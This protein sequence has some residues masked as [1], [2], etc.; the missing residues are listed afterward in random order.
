MKKKI[1]LVTSLLILTILL[2]TPYFTPT[3]TAPTPGP[4]PV[5]HWKIMLA[6]QA[7]N[8]WIVGWLTF[9]G[10]PIPGTN[11]FLNCTCGREEPQPLGQ[12]VFWKQNTSVIPTDIEYTKFIDYTKDGQP[13]LVEPISALIPS[14]GH[15]T[16]D[17]PQTWY[18]HVETGQGPYGPWMVVVE[19]R[20]QPYDSERPYFEWQLTMK[21]HG[22][23]AIL[24]AYLTKDQA[25]LP[26][27]DYIL[28]GTH[29]PDLQCQVRRTPFCTVPND[30]HVDLLI[31]GLPPPITI[32]QVITQFPWTYKYELVPGVVYVELELTEVHM[33]HYWVMG[34]ETN[35]DGQ[36]GTFDPWFMDDW[37]P[38]RNGSVPFATRE[39]LLSPMFMDQNITFTQRD[40]ITGIVK[41]GVPAESYAGLDHTYYSVRVGTYFRVQIFLEIQGCGW[42]FTGIG[43]RPILGDVNITSWSSNLGTYSFGPDGLPK[44]GDDVFLSGNATNAA[45]P[46]ATHAAGAGPPLGPCLEELRGP[47]DIPGTGDL[48]DP[49]GDG[50]PDPPGSSILYLPSTMQVT[51][52]SGSAWLSLFGSPW[53]QLL[54][55][56]KS[57]NVVLEPASLI[58]GVDAYS[59]GHPWEFRAGVDHP[60]WPPVPWEH[61]F[62]NAYVKYVCVWSVM[63]VDTAM[64]WLDVHFKVV[65]K[66]FR[67]APGTSWDCVLPD[68]MAENEYVTISDIRKAAK[69]YD[70]YDEGFGSPKADPLYDGAADVMDPRGWVSI[71][72][73]RRIAKDYQKQLTPN[74]IIQT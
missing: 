70:Q 3:A 62:S 25:Q 56:A 6:Q 59:V 5:Y 55:T 21:T 41:L 37:M 28:E 48:D 68:I 72:D 31:N 35:S 17:E 71:G 44:T 19:V 33:E 11:F 36:L 58:N 49:F 51:Y 42:L 7:C 26:G 2:T 29:E 74:G 73:I 20:E 43:K 1:A 40:P 4:G 22:L 23:T 32:D 16:P 34:G 50:T 52:W 12:F 27:T 53:P 66:K 39:P 57:R 9:Q 63:D 69:A 18:E 30:I 64:G 13:D 61:K 65:E 45:P 46:P 14:P 67:D 47:D 15:P 54:T 38:D 8:A 10:A 60:E 24:T